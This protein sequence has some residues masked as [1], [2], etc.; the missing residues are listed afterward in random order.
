MSEEI[1]LRQKHLPMDFFTLIL[2]LI[3]IIQWIT[4]DMYLPAL[5][6]LKQEFHTTEAVL[7]IPVWAYISVSPYVYIDEF[8]V[9]NVAQGL[10]HW[11]AVYWQ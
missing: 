10:F 1:L 6:V 8:G 4:L 11:P 5:P 9:S 3:T 7:T 2:V